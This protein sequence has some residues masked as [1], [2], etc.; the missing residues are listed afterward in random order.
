[1][2]FSQGWVKQSSAMT[3]EPEAK[4]KL[5]LARLAR[6]QATSRPVSESLP[7]QEMQ[8]QDSLQ[9]LRSTAFPA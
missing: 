5:V 7:G 4:E 8:E 6:P 1:M 9:R 3:T 2:D